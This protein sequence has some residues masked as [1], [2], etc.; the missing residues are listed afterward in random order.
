[1]LNFPSARTE[2]SEIRTPYSRAIYVPGWLPNSAK[3][4]IK[5]NHQN[6]TT[7]FL[8]LPFRVFYLTSPNGECTYNLLSKDSNDTATYI[9]LMGT[10]ESPSPTD[11]K[12]V[13]FVRNYSYYQVVSFF[14]FDFPLI[15][16]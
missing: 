12:N 6:F 3:K 1:M 8:S 9:S 15:H 10:S 2:H 5:S 13:T 16:P 4:Y 7:Q 14:F 11:S